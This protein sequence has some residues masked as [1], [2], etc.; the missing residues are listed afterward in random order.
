M[1]FE[2]LVGRE[3]DQVECDS[4][5]TPAIHHRVLAH[6]CATAPYFV[7][8]RKI[9]GKRRGS[10]STRSTTVQRLPKMRPT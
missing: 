4:R 2:W 1:N 5:G 9:S 3:G 7:S 6:L 8:A 10:C